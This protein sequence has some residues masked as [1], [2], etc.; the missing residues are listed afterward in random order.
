MPPSRRFP[1]PA[2]TELEG[3][4]RPTSTPRQA[5][6]GEARPSSGGR[7][8]A[9]LPTRVT[10]ASVQGAPL[11]RSAMSIREFGFQDQPVSSTPTASHHRRAHAPAGGEAARPRQGAGERRQ[12]PLP[13]PGQGLSPGRQPHRRGDQLGPRA[14]AARARGPARARLRH[15]RCSASTPMSSRPCSPSPLRA[16][17]TP[18]RCPN[19]RA[20]RSHEPGDLWLLGAAPPAVRRR[21]QSRATC[22]A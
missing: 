19:R 1:W 22:S 8:V 10:R 20:S 14:A 6:D 16:S 7:Q 9:P 11:T 3:P 5:G 4:T 12:R 15:R 18:T 21:H 13:R 17:P 2:R